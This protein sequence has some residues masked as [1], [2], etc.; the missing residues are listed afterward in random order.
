MIEIIERVYAPNDGVC[1]ECGDDL[2]PGDLVVWVENR[3]R[4]HEFCIEEPE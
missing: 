3:G 4:V 1:G 2:E